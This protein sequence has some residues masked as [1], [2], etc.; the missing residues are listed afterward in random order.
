LKRALDLLFSG[1]GVWPEAVSAVY[2]AEPV[3]FC[4]PNRFYNLAV[5]LRTSLSP[6]EL[7]VRCLEIELRLGRK[8]S[9]RLED[10]IVDLDLLFYGEAVIE[11]GWV[12]VPHPRAHERAFVLLPLAEIAPDLKHPVLGKTVQELLRDLPVVSGIRRLG[13]LDLPGFGV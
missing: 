3:G 4:S 6:W 11:G 8:R 2:L 5:S 7:M 13:K 10:R 9:G 1:R 12:R